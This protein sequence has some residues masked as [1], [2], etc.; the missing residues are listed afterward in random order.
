MP[1][2]TELLTAVNNLTKIEP[3]K[4]L[5]L[6]NQRTKGW[7]EYMHLV[8]FVHPV[9]GVLRIWTGHITSLPGSHGDGFEIDNVV[10]T[11]VWT[12]LPLRNCDRLNDCHEKTFKVNNPLLIRRDEVHFFK[13][14]NLA[15]K[16]FHGVLSPEEIGL[17]VKLL[18]MEDFG[19]SFQAPEMKGSTRRFEEVPSAQSS[20]W[21]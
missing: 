4:D 16:W 3:A 13:D 21:K 6:P 17:V 8:L 10:K 11:V 7:I 2:N 19:L 20:W 14:E 1:T 5:I 15:L 9:D 18:S 12:D